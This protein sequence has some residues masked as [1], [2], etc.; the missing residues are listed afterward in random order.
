MIVF[1]TGTGRCGTMTIANLL[2]AEE[3]AL[4]LHEGKVR[5]RE[6]SGEQFLPFLTLQ[7]YLAYRSPHEAYDM[8]REARKNVPEL[9]S[10]YALFG[11][12]AY[13]YAPFV[14]VIPELLPE[15]K[16]L[17]VF[18]NGRSFIRSAYTTE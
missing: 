18:R 5:D 16:L 3:E 9:A 7:N 4:C 6:E 13:N 2:N 11:D 14:R 1:G 12:I 17:V 8:L 10:R 15:A